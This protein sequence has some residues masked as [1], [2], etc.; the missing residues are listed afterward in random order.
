MRK[1]Q[2]FGSP[3]EMAAVNSTPTAGSCQL[4]RTVENPVGVEARSCR[5]LLA[6]FTESGLKLV[7]LSIALARDPALRRFS[8]LFSSWAIVQGGVNIDPDGNIGIS[9]VGGCGRRFG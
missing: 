1:R 5:G 9:H 4:K 2:F 3:D 8:I 6:D 7:H